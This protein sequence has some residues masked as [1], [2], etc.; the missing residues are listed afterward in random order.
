M[1]LDQEFPPHQLNISLKMLMVPVQ[2][3]AAPVRSGLWHRQGSLV[4][5]RLERGTTAT[6]ARD[7]NRL[8]VLLPTASMQSCRALSADQGAFG[9]TFGLNVPETRPTNYI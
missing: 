9:P 2:V 8:T 4:H 6:Q 1:R 5:V 3:D 7:R